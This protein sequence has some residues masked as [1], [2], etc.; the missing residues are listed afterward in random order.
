MICKNGIFTVL[1]ANP[2][3]VRGRCVQI[4][5]T[6][7][8]RSDASEPRFGKLCSLL[9]EDA[10]VSSSCAMGSVHTSDLMIQ[11]RGMGLI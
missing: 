4:S 10:G 2:Y 6:T 5:T 1:R 11:I 8:R 7:L 9:G 3:L